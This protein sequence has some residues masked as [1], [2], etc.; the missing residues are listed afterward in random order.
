M[1][2]ELTNLREQ[3][4]QCALDLLGVIDLLVERVDTLFYLKLSCDG[5]KVG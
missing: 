3:S 5:V 2:D 1:M 4:P